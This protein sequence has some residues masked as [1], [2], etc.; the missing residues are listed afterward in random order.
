MGKMVSGTR[1]QVDSLWST[2]DGSDQIVFTGKALPL[3]ADYVPPP[4]VIIEKERVVYVDREVPVEVIK[5]VEK[6]VI[7]EIP[8]IEVFEIIKEKIVEI[9]VERIVERI[10]EQ[11]VEVPV[12][13]VV[14]KRVEVP[15][16]VI[17][18]IQKPFLPFWAKVAMGVQLVVILGLMLTS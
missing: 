11:R 2:S 10:V 17:R 7:Q 15:T 13:V 3:I 18:L 4:P 16:D 14:E 6:I 12:E 1:E 8:K 5:E 9:P